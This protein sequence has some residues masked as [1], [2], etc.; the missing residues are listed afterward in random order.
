MRKRFVQSHY[1]RDL[2]QKLRKLKQGSWT[3]EEYYQEINF[4]VLRACISGDRQAIMARFLEDL[5]VRYKIVWRCNIMWRQK[6]CY[7]KLFL[8]NNS[9]RERVTRVVVMEPL[10]SKTLRMTN[11]AIRR[12]EN[13]KRKKNLSRAISKPSMIG[14]DKVLTQNKQEK[15]NLRKG[16]LIRLTGS[17]IISKHK[18]E[19]YI[20]IKIK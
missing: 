10:D 9:F 18:T 11:Q 6:I 4:L 5:T 3:V 7:T 12:R 17:F 20:E 15:N 16:Y 14:E 2:H 8:W 1:H 13:H 19:E